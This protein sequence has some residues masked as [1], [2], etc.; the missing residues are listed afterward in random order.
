M[1][2]EF[3]I[4]KDHKGVIEFPYTKEAKLKIMVQTVQEDTGLKS[5]KWHEKYSLSI[6]ARDADRIKNVML[7]V[8]CM[9]DDR[10]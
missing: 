9:L 7:G 8:S 1:M 4:N 10:E 2:I 3:T 5:K 6:S